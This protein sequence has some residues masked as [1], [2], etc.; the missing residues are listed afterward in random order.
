MTMLHRD[1]R[2]PDQ[3]SVFEKMRLL[4]EAKKEQTHPMLEKTAHGLDVDV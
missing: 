4:M 2:D 1:G 3:T